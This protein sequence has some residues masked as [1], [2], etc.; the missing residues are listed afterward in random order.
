[1]GNLLGSKERRSGP[2]CKL[3]A[4]TEIRMLTG[5]KKFLTTAKIFVIIKKITQIMS[6]LVFI[7]RASERFPL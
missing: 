3:N 2:I 6:S 4:V 7:K 5:A 1:M